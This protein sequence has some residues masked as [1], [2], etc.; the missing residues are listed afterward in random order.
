MR[1]VCGNAVSKRVHSDVTAQ[2]SSILHHNGEL[3]GMRM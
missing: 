3:M 2:L 1:C